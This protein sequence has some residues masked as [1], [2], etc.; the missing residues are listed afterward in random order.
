MRVHNIDDIQVATSGDKNARYADDI[1]CWK[2]ISLV[3][4]TTTG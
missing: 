2:G 4:V 3:H 1:I